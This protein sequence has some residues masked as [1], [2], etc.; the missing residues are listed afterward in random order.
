VR[1][2]REE[3]G[4]AFGRIQG[5]HPS[6]KGRGYSIGAL[7]F[8]LKQHSY[9]RLGVDFYRDCRY[10]LVRSGT[11]KIG[12]PNIFFL[13]SILIHS[14]VLIVLLYCYYCSMDFTDYFTLLSFQKKDKKRV[15]EKCGW[16]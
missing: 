14:W 8:R 15:K 3:E 1:L 10:I 7:A 12:S 6:L 4:H 9:Q 2:G 13:S 11:W 5:L 16:I